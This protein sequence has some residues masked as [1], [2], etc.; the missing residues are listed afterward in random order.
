MPPVREIILDGGV[1]G[2]LKQHLP[3]G[4]AEG[5]I[6]TAVADMPGLEH[7]QAALTRS[8]LTVRD[9]FSEPLRIGVS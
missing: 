7:Y 4:E 9:Y 5:D 2:A 8:R 1:L 6:F 3:E